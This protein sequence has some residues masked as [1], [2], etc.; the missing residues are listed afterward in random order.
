MLGITAQARFLNN[1]G[2]DR[3]RSRL[4][5]LGLPP[6]T[7]QANRAGLTDLVRPGGLGGFKVMVQG[8]N[9]GRPELWGWQPAAEPMDLVEKLDLPLLSPRHLSQ[10]EGR[11]PPGEFELD[12]GDL[13]PSVDQPSEDLPPGNLERGAS[14]NDS[15]G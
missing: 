9:V 5:S 13:W 14:G 10:L 11:Y 3:F 6:G 15:P 4:P 12:P 1:L 7:L 2:L 8:R